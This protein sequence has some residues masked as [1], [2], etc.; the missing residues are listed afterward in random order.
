[1]IVRNMQNQDKPLPLVSALLPS[2]N[3]ADFISKTL[4]SLAAQTWPN[5]EILIG[6]D[7]S[8]DAT[9]DIVVEFARDRPNVRILGRSNNLGWL[10]N[11]NDLMANATG[12]MMFF[13]FHDDVIAPDYVE[14]LARALLGRPD[15]VLAYS[16][17]LTTERDGAVELETFP[18]VAAALTPLRRA[19]TM[20]YLQHYW[21]APNR[22]VFRASGYR[23]VGGI[24]RNAAGEFVADWTWL[25]HLSLIGN[26]VHVPQTLC[27]KYYKPNSLSRTWERSKAQRKALREAGIAEIRRSNA[28]LRTKS[29]LIFLLATAVPRQNL[30]QWSRKIRR[31]VHGKLVSLLR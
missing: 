25:L 19:L 8:T 11:S 23:E 21:W 26:F 1:M 30:R 17:M 31:R 4:D 27:W 3:S 24:H 2:Y 28:P 6:D 16:D 7:C 12:E 18:S 15:A 29:I 20:L 14:K 22:G 9:R 10:A 5:L 13:A